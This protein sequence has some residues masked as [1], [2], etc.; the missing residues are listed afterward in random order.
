MFL[1]CWLCLVFGLCVA[2]VSFVVFVVCLIDLLNCVCRVCLVVW[3]SRV[4]ATSCC[5]L[6]VQVVWVACARHCVIGF[7]R[8]MSTSLSFA[9]G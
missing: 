7:V 1:L 2:A 6:C 8:A 3:L 4:A 9:F 5:G